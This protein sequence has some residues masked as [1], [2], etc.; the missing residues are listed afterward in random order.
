L[1]E[2]EADGSMIFPD[3]QNLSQLAPRNVSVTRPLRL[4]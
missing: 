2:A 1:L 3:A 4:A